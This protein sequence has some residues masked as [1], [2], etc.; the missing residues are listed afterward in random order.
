MTCLPCRL[1]LHLGSSY[2]VSGVFPPAALLQGGVG[3][4]CASCS[5]PP[6][7]G[8]PSSSQPVPLSSPSVTSPSPLRLR[9]PWILLRTQNRCFLKTAVSAGSSDHRFR[10]LCINTRRR[11][12]GALCPG[13]HRPCGCPA[14][15]RFPR[16]AAAPW[17]SGPWLQS[18]L[19]KR[20]AY[21]GPILPRLICPQPRAGRVPTPQPLTRREGLPPSHSKGLLQRKGRSRS[22]RRAHPLLPMPLPGWRHRGLTAGGAA[23]TVEWGCGSHSQTPAQSLPLRGRRLSYPPILGLS[24]GMTEVLWQATGHSP[25]LQGLSLSISSGQSQGW[26]R[27]GGTGRALH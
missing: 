13:S 1:P 19:G 24:P 17:P 4:A 26:P 25:R 5:E 21:P 20:V 12:Q 10:L 6:P 18:H 3:T 15:G 2:R 23:S 27:W 9:V 22:L 7:R 16:W 14:D 11:S 8:P